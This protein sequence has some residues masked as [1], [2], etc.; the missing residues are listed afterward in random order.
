M[1]ISIFSNIL[2]IM[3]VS[4]QK[5][6]V[7]SIQVWRISRI[8]AIGIETISFWSSCFNFQVYPC[9]ISDGFQT[10]YYI[11]LHERESSKLNL[12]KTNSGK[13][14]RFVSL[15]RH[16]YIYIQLLSLSMFALQS[17]I[18]LNRMSATA[19]TLYL[20]LKFQFWY[21]PY[22]H[23]VITLRDLFQNPVHELY[24]IRVKKNK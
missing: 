4:V 3:V 19:G 16:L 6:R 24:I 22:A 15:H 11:N 13:Y 12:F 5:S 10:V 17:A 2:I 8:C 21:A 1:R 7:K 20:W 18:L 14:S 9:K 23:K